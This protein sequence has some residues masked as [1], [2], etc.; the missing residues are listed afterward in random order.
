MN[1]TLAERLIFALGFIAQSIT[2][3]KTTNY[4]DVTGARRAGVAI[5]DDADAAG[6]TVQVQFKVADDSSGT[7]AEN[8]GSAVD[9]T[10]DD[11]GNI[12][13]FT[14]TQIEGLPEGKTHL[15][16][17]ITNTDSPADMTSTTATL[18]LGDLRFRP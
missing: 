1:S 2:S 7:N 10:A 12:E 6:Q 13:L 16:A 15:A 18:V 5:V 11:S 3:A 14:D 4:V 17:E 9:L 8:F